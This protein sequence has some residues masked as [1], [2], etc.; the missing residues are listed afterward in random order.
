MTI[1]KNLKIIICPDSFKGSLS[2][3]DVADLIAETL[4][5]A[6]SE[7]DQTLEVVKFPLADGGEGTASILSNKYPDKISV[8]TK[9]PLGRPIQVDYFANLEKGSAFIESASAIGLPLLSK[10]ERNPLKCTSFGLGLLI[11]DAL[12]KGCDKITVS[13]GGSATC[14][15]GIGMLKALGY[16]FLDRNQKELNCIGED[17]NLIHKIEDSEISP[18]LK[19]VDFSAVCDVRNPLLGEYGASPVFAPQKGAS[20][21]DVKILE[22]GLKNYVGKTIS[23]GF[24]QDSDAWKPGAGAAGG[25]GFSLQSFINAEYKS[26]ID[27]VL[28]SLDFNSRIKGADLIITGEGKIDRQSLMGKVLEGVLKRANLNNIPVIAVGGM[29]EDKEELMKAGILS[30]YEISVTSHSLEFNMKPE[31]AKQNL[32]VTL[33]KIAVDLNQTLCP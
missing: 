15:G 21:D 23:F 28:D 24:S 4:S 22:T 19:K 27:F 20:P 2:A 1:R 32:K 18:I 11:L 8:K 5:E 16:K 17:L 25:L 13:L 31:I 6:F 3:H 14:D 10:E 33:K 30:I 26:G 29:I 9:D 7:Y 12:Q